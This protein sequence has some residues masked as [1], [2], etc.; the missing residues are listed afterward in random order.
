MVRQLFLVVLDG[1]RGLKQASSTAL[2]AEIRLHDFKAFEW[3]QV[4]SRKMAG[5]RLSV[6]VRK[7]GFSEASQ[8]WVSPPIPKTLGLYG[9]AI[10]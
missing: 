2:E 1:G 4:P 10:C 5:H 3:C 6:A 8:H 9:F 7:G